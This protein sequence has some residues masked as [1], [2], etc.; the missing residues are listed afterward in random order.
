MSKL[1][2]IEGDDTSTNRDHEESTDPANYVPPAAGAVTN[3]VC[4]V[5][6]TVGGIFVAVEAWRLGLGSLG[7]PRSG[8]WPAVLSVLLM[9]LGL[10]IALRARHFH[11]AEKI[12]SKAIGVAVGAVA[13]LVSTQLMP[14]IGFEIPAFALMVFWMSVLG[15][16]KYR[17][18]IPVGLAAVLA[19]YLIFVT[20][21][22]VPLPRLF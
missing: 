6:I 4:G 18:S 19:T 2:T 5:F 9:A 8:T 21:L 15:G 3:L 22:S 13:L 17:I 16:E 10:A 1:E 12:T 7:A 11:D 14:L 20:G